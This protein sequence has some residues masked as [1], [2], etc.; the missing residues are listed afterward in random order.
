MVFHY[1][2]QVSI[3][4]DGPDLPEKSSRI[5]VEQI[6]SCMAYHFRASSM[7]AASRRRRGGG[8][9]TSATEMNLMAPLEIRKI[10][11]KSERFAAKVKLHAFSKSGAWAANGL[12][13]KLHL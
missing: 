1:L 13:F 2:H 5:H 8:G 3:V 4:P 11:L 7:V 12:V 6:V 9:M 10:N